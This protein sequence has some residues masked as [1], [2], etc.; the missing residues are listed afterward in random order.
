[1]TL[2]PPYGSRK[3]WL[4]PGVSQ[5]EVGVQTHRP[6][7]PPPAHF[8]LSSLSLQVLFL[9]CLCFQWSF[10]KALCVGL[11]PFYLPG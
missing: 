2:V 5:Q 4:L 1:M 3:V 8:S 7:V 6:N 11:F 9:L 10:P